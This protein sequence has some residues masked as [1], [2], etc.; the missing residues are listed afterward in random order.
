MHAIEPVLSNVARIKAKYSKH[1]PNIKPLRGG[2][3]SAERLVN[4][5][6]YNLLR[7]ESTWPHAGIG[8]W[9]P[10][11]EGVSSMKSVDASFAK[12]PAVF[13]VYKIDAATQSS[14]TGRWAYGGT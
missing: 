11:I 7:Q 8:R 1:L 5:S 9:N 13:R 6:T 14:N 12:D 4:D 3:G 10:Q 2:L